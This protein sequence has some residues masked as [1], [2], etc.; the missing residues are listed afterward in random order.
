MGCTTALECQ[1]ELSTGS[2]TYMTDEETKGQRDL[3]PDP[4]FV[5]ILLRR[6]P[7]ARLCI[8]FPPVAVLVVDC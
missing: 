4:D 5:I 2:P 7:N 3:S 6:I 1:T 8:A